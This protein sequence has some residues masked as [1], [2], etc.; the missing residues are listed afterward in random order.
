MERVI[1]TEP[2][3]DAADD[4][5]EQLTY[6][7]TRQESLLVCRLMLRT[8]RETNNPYY[9][10]MYADSFVDAARK[11]LGTLKKAEAAVGTLEWKEFSHKAAVAVEEGKPP[12]TIGSDFERWILAGGPEP[13]A[14][15]GKVNCFEMV[16][17]SAYKGGF[18]SKKR[19]ADIY[20]EGLKQWKATGSSR[21]V[22]DI[23]EAELRTGNEYVF[24]PGDPKSPQP[25]PGDIVIFTRAKTHAAISRGTKDAKGRPEV[26]SLWD[27]PNANK[28]V[29]ETTIEEL[30]LSLPSSVVKFWNPK[31]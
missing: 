10:G 2:T 3:V 7:M 15:A 8:L 22:G 17:F 30:L 26:I 12:S 19:I 13:D 29:Q 9:V 28:T 5:S 1:Q 24:N 20:N 4:R 21:G 6:K 25:L 27:R 23:L 31:W 18:T 16:L 14:T 11:Q